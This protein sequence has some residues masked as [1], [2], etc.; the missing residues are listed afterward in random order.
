MV[1][2][3]L[4]PHENLKI[5]RNPLDHDGPALE[6]QACRF[7]LAAS[8]FTGHIRAGNQQVGNHEE[9]EP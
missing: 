1:E 7:G 4:R 5:S 8:V 6:D 9:S 2:G 3:H